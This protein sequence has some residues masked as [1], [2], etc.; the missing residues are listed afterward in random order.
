MKQK[1]LLSAVE[2]SSHELDEIPVS[3][4]HFI[5]IIMYEY[6]L[7]EREYRRRA[8]HTDFF[9]SRGITYIEYQCESSLNAL[10][11]MNAPVNPC[12]SRKFMNVYKS[13]RS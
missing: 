12:E 8:H 2:A 5:F 6:V 13:Y 9:P 3:G 1:F 7:N 4:I 11:S 10:K